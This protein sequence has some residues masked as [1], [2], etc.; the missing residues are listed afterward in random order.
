MGNYNTK[1]IF[2]GRGLSNDVFFFSSLLWKS[3]ATA[4]EKPVKAAN[5]VASGLKANVQSRF[6]GRAGE[7]VGAEKKHAISGMNTLS[8]KSWG[9]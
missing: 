3:R 5:A 8:G 7:V 6:S 1:V 2:S 4:R 9:I